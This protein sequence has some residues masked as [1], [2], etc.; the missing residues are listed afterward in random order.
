[1]LSSSSSPSQ[2][3]LLSLLESDPVNSFFPR[4][5]KSILLKLNS[6]FYGLSSSDLAEP[7]SLD[8]SDEIMMFET[9]SFKSLNSVWAVIEEV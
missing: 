7:P 5:L 2:S 6:W 1:M 9:P 4:G 3:S 8:F